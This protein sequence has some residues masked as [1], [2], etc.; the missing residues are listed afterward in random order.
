MNN[1]IYNKSLIIFTLF[2]VIIQSIS[3]IQLLNNHSL[4]SYEVLKY[5]M[6]LIIAIILPFIAY[7]NDLWAGG[8]SKLFTLF[9]IL[10]PIKYVVNKK[11][12]F[13]TQFNVFITIF[14][15][16]FIFIIFETIFFIVKDILNGELKNK[17]KSCYPFLI[18]IEK[19]NIKKFICKYMFTY[20]LISNLNKLYILII[21]NFYHNNIF[22]FM[23]INV[24]I[25]FK[26]FNL[27]KNVK[28]IYL[29]TISMF[30]INYILQTI[31]FKI[32]KCIYFNIDI[33]LLILLIIIMF[34]RYIG[35]LYNYK[36]IVIKDLREGMIL[37]FSTILIFQKSR[38]KDLPHTT[39]ETVKSRIGQSEVNAIKRWSKSKY[40]KNNIIIVRHIPF[41]PFIF[42]GFFIQMILN[43]LL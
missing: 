32:Y 8:D 36:K 1:K 24:V 2:G 27:I 38:V 35:K 17:F 34:F 16:A 40:G 21:N 30:I 7:I 9:V 4:S 15:I 20:F 25:V 42:L 23:L 11:Y 19:K 5:V 31:L 39:T 3:L 12:F 33:K 22:L 6:N 29:I 13:T 10:F 14:S 28:I 18:K 43:L 41:A 37:S 26:L